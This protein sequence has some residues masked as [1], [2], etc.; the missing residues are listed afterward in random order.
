MHFTK[1]YL[2]LGCIIILKCELYSNEYRFQVCQALTIN[3]YTLL[4]NFQKQIDI[5]DFPR[6]PNLSKAHYTQ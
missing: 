2:Y 6:Q 5:P 4:D 1:P 3:S